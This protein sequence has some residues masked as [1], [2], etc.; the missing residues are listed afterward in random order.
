MSTLIPTPTQRFLA[1]E[2]LKGAEAVRTVSED[3]SLAAAYC[4]GE[5][6]ITNSVRECVASLAR[7]RVPAHW[8]RLCVSDGLATGPLDSW[9]SKL[10]RR[11]RGLGAYSPLLAG[12]GVGAAPEFNVALMFSPEPFFTATRQ[13]AA[14][15]PIS[16]SS[17]VFVPP[18]PCRLFWSFRR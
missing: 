5:A 11:L 1:R 3:L 10:A 18:H 15:V 4:N 14:Q 2:V 6:K 16:T 7:S 9:I 8:Q 17:L 13:L 12:G